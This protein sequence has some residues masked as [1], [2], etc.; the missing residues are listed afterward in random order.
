MLKRLPTKDML[1]NMG[2]THDLVCYLCGVANADHEHLFYQCPFSSRCIATLQ[3]KLHVKINTNRLNQWNT[4]GRERLVLQRRLICAAHIGITYLI[5]TARNKA[6]FDHLVSHPDVI[7]RLAIKTVCERFWSRN[8]GIK[9][10]SLIARKR[11]GWDMGPLDQLLEHV[12]NIKD[13]NANGSLDNFKLELQNTIGHI[14]ISEATL[15]RYFNVISS[16]DLNKAI[17]ISNEMSQLEEARKFHLS[18]YSQVEKGITSADTSKNE[19][20]RAMTSRLAALTEELASAVNLCAGTTITFQEMID[21][22]NCC[23]HFG[24][25]KIRTLITQ[26]SEKNPKIQIEGSL[27]KP[28][29]SVPF[30]SK[31]DYASKSDGNPQVSNPVLAVKYNAS[32]AKAAEMERHSSTESDESSF[33][34][35]DDQ[36]P[37][38][39]SRTMARSASPRRSASPMR[40][41]QIGKSGSRR[42]P[43]LAI[44][45]LPYFPPR[46]RISSHKDS[47]N[48]SDSEVVEEP[49]KKT[50]VNV[51]RISV[52]DAI[53]LF[54][55][56]QKD[57]IVDGQ[58]KSVNDNS[59]NLNKAVLR[60]WSSGMRETQKS[61]QNTQEDATSENNVSSFEEDTLSHAEAKP[62]TMKDVIGPNGNV[63]L[64]LSLDVDNGQDCQTDETGE[65][66]D[67][68][69]WSRQKEAELNQMLMKFAQ[70]NLSNPKNIESDNI[71]NHDSRLPKKGRVTSNLN[72]GNSGKDETLKG[73][74]SG[75]KVEKQADLLRVKRKVVEKPKVEK[76]FVKAT[77]SRASSTVNSSSRIPNVT[78]NIPSLNSKKESPKPDVLKRAPSKPSPI[79]ATRKSWPSTPSPRA[80]GTVSAK[81][82]TG[83][84]SGI[85]A[86]RQ[87]SQPPGSGQRSSSL[88]SRQKP[89]SLESCQKL[90]SPVVR[91]SPKLEKS[92]LQHKIVQKLQVDTKKNLRKVEDSKTRVLSKNGKLTKTKSA[93][94]VEEEGAVSP[95]KAVTRKKGTKKSSVVPIEPK[96]P[97]RK[98]SGST[99]VSSP[100]KKTNISVQ[101]EQTATECENPSS[102]A[103]NDETQ[104]CDNIYPLESIQTSEAQNDFL[105]LKPELERENLE[106]ENVKTI[107]IQARVEDDDPTKRLQDSPGEIHE[108]VISPAAWEENNQQDPTFPIGNGSLPDP[109][110]HDIVASSGTRVRHSLSQM[111]L[112]E[113]S[114]LDIIEWGNAE[115]PPAMI[116]QKDAPKGLK[117]LLKFTRK[118]KGEMNGSTWASPYTSEGEDDG[119]DYRSLGKR[120]SD[121]LLKVAL[122]SK[123]HG[124]GFLS[125]SEPLSARSNASNSSARSSSK[126]QDWHTTKGTK[127]FFS[128]S[129]FRGNKS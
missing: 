118:N 49:N 73:E 90:Q 51:T 16:S 127:S 100:L 48:D 26:L 60:R 13:Q 116:Y 91:S 36:P 46:E 109:V 92:Q 15:M 101:A 121:N 97:S 17:A 14:P 45:S 106:S 85:I 20:L 40:K 24:D 107:A 113:S 99:P 69:E 129:A 42:T 6:R 93:L 9:R 114:E 111:L 117:R 58:K 35:E 25:V 47:E 50:E 78:K 87:K 125:D 62:V 29:L 110:N 23:Q 18:L 119:D 76:P 64:Q 94:A 8:T 95:V 115:N 56:K 89:P 70:Y 82:S 54:E 77:S 66:T 52:Q 57:D 32:P 21:L 38:E 108:P 120:N 41:V 12:T 98:V 19:L 88:A 96:P 53:S 79:P 123:N 39:R 22:Q 86:S 5:W 104:I 11:K 55:R 4:K 33:S 30:V 63:D 28:K 102:P 83:P 31:S 112:E 37:A 84:P 27:D 2:I 81:I 71:K 124:E 3:S 68:V 126:F 74:I 105:E 10:E 103:K 1:A 128:L 34:S 67:S 61:N 44:R 122:H 72:Q 75:K 80:L 65:K 59:V 7:V 43:A